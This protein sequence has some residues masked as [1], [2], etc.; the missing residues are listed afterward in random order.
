MKT[1]QPTEQ[2]IQMMEILLH[3]IE[4][5]TN[6]AHFVY[7]KE[8]NSFEYQSINTALSPVLTHYTRLSHRPWLGKDA[9]KRK[10][11]DSRQQVV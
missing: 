3:H 10:M 8:E 4:H 9:E 2:D 7:Q 5:L 11:A 1:K 6:L